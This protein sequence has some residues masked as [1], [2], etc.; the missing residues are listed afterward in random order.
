MVFF[1]PETSPTVQRYFI[2]QIEIGKI[3]LSNKLD[4]GTGGKG[5]L[6]SS[7]I[8]ILRIFLS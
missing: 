8:L 1:F 5:G 4:L 7:Q 2:A 3:L 6:W